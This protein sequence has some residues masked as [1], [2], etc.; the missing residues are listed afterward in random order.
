MYLFTSKLLTFSCVKVLPSG[1][2]C[3]EFWW[4]LMRALPANSNFEGISSWIRDRIFLGILSLVTGRGI[5]DV[6]IVPGNGAAWGTRGTLTGNWTWCICCYACFLRWTSN[7]R[8]CFTFSTIWA[9]G[10]LGWARKELLITHNVGC[11]SV[12]FD[13][14][15]PSLLAAL[16][17]CLLHGLLVRLKGALGAGILQ[18]LITAQSYTGDFMSSCWGL[19]HDYFRW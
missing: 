18:W 6:F 8:K 3:T 17:P 10:K 7:L 2:A 1:A 4:R 15:V 13:R 14:L 9:H 5:L 16:T 12:N 11:C 19:M